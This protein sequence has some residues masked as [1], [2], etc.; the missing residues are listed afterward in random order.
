MVAV[1]CFMG[2]VVLTFFTLY[3]GTTLPARSRHVLFGGGT[4]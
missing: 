3:V 1:C 4:A 2:V